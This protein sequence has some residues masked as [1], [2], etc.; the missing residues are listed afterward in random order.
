MA[1]GQVTVVVKIR[2]K[3]G[4]E[5]EVRSRLAALL[6]PTRAEEGCLNFDMHESPEDA[7]LFL[8]HENWRSQ[9]DLDRHFQTPYITSW[10]QDAN[11]LLA[12]PMELSLWRAVEPA[13]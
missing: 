2:A 9:G 4:S 10:V 1:T 3:P 12:E 5:G 6:A 13:S 7:S 8:F 11:S